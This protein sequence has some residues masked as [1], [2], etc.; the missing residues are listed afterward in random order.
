MA[1]ALVSRFKDWPAKVDGCYGLCAIAL[2]DGNCACSKACKHCL[3][4]FGSPHHDKVKFPQSLLPNRKGRGLVCDN[5]VLTANWKYN[6]VMSS[7]KI[8]VKI[9][10]LSDGHDGW[11]LIVMEWE[12]ENMKDGGRLKRR[13]GDVEINIKNSVGVTARR[14][15]GV[16]WPLLEWVDAFGGEPPKDRIQTIVVKGFGPC[17]GI[18]E[19]TSKGIRMNCFE[20]GTDRNRFITIIITKADTNTYAITNKLTIQKQ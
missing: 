9:Q 7:Q 17:T 20:L 15:G 2:G 1:L 19:E 11:Q 5:C 18:V 12:D 10:L 4:S 14:N 6:E 13:R 3:R 8:A 16:L